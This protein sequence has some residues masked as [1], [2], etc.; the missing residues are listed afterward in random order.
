[1]KYHNI[2]TF[3]KGVKYD[4]KKEARR[5]Y[6]LDL[7]QRSGLISSLELQKRIELQPSFKVNGKTERAITYL[8]DFYYYD[9]VKKIW[10]VEDVKSS[11][12]RTLPVYRIK[13]KLLLYKYPDTVFIET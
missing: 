4:S 10:V 13:K 6:E 5:A 7:L 2:K 1:M 9:T 12:T 8:A 11:I 3:Y